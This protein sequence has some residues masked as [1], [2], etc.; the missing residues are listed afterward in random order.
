MELQVFG[1]LESDASKNPIPNVPVEVRLDERR[2]QIQIYR[3]SLCDFRIFTV[4][5]C[6]SRLR[7]KD[8]KDLTD[9]NIRSATFVGPSSA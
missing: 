7:T 5:A 9:R 4:S 1:R 8:L 6:G 2:R 3:I